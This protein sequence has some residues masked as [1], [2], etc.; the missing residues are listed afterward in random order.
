MRAIDD[1]RPIRRPPSRPFALRSRHAD[2]PSVGGLISPVRCSKNA[3]HAPRGHGSRIAPRHPRSPSF[4][5]RRASSKSGPV[6][7]SSYQAPGSH[8]RRAAS[9]PRKEILM[10]INRH[11]V[12]VAA[13][14]GLMLAAIGAGGV[15]NA[16]DPFSLSST[17]FKDGTMMP[18][19]VANKNP[20]KPEL[21]RR[22]CVAGA[23][24][25]GRSGRHQELRVHHGRPGRPWR[26]RCVPLGGLR[27]SGRT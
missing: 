17:T 3:P 10:V 9:I 5:Q 6:P 2:A 15:A 21:R 1:K 16:A 22:Q 26:S 13:A 8:G 14:G 7:V 11:I 20:A 4:H 25:E 19:K 27:H 18:K 23:V 12:S 24:V